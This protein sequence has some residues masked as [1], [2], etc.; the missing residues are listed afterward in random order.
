[1]ITK[2]IDDHI[3]MHG[4]QKIILNHD[5]YWSVPDNQIFDVS[6]IPKD[7]SIGSLEDEYSSL[8]KNFAANEMLNCVSMQH[9]GALLIYIS[10]KTGENASDK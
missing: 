6:V 10:A 3:Y 5:L 2:A 4:D 7:L 9:L 1:M 8:L